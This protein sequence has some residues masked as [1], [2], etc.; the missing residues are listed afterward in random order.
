MMPAVVP[1]I[2]RS[3]D[4]RRATILGLTALFALGG[5]ASGPS[6]PAPPS[7]GDLLASCSQEENDCPPVEAILESGYHVPVYKTIQA[8][9]FEERRTPVWGEKTVEV[10]Q[11]RKVPVTIS[12]PNVCTGCDHDVTL[13]DKE[14]RVQVGTRRVRACLGYRTKRVVVGHCPKQVQVGWRLVAEQSDCAPGR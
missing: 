13:W 12:V 5:C 8:P 4:V 10:Y 6:L 9:I 11:T 2:G 14:E 3:R 1:P 7:P